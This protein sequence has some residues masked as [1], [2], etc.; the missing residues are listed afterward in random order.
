MFLLCS[1]RL[2]VRGATSG[3]SWQ[4][5]MDSQYRRTCSIQPV[6]KQRNG[7]PR[8]W[9]STHRA[10][11]T[12][13]YG[14][15]LETC[16]GAYRDIAE[17]KIVE[18]NPDDYPGGI[19][20]WGAVA[21]VYDTTGLPSESGIHVHARADAMDNEK[22][23]DDTFDA[24][25]IRYGRDLLQ[26]HQAVITSEVAVSYY[27][28]RF[29]NR[30]MKFLRCPKCGELHLDSG[31]FAI[32]VHRRHLC[33]G[34]G[35]YFSDEVKAVSNPI[36]ALHAAGVVPTAAF[37]PIRPERTLDIRQADYPGG[38]QVWASN[39]ALI[40]SADRPEE[41]GLHVHAF[42]S[43]DECVID[44]TFGNVRIDGV[45]LDEEQVKYLMAQQALPHL[46]N[47][48]VG[49]QCPDCREPHFDQGDCAVFPHIDHDCANCGAF[50][51]S[52]G[53]RRMVV[54]NPFVETRAK[55]SAQRRESR[56]SS[57]EPS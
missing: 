7:K 25:R 46:A 13:R 30:E 38:L 35:R 18:L 9:C 49:L 10:G 54:S 50:F 52:P 56:K 40:W 23:I 14:A 19:A 55:L 32:K 17:R 15:R 36:V 16:E 41:E 1:D 8:F 43:S 21:P 24:V 34:C 31:Y 2:K 20:L 27:L 45:E 29:S 44:D 47:K 6:G 48:I 3:R 5:D 37:K 28:S 57:G 26:E 22:R 42:S 51:S 12:G 11:A 33:H 4:V 53:Q 39:P